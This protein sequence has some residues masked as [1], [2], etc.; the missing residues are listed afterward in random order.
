MD[1]TSGDMGGLLGFLAARSPCQNGSKEREMGRDGRG[2]DG[3]PWR[4]LEAGCKR[5]PGSLETWLFHDALAPRPLPVASPHASMRQGRGPGSGYHGKKGRQRR[6]WVKITMITDGNIGGAAASGLVV[7]Q[8]N[9]EQP[10]R[11]RQVVWASR[12]Q[13]V[14]K[15]IGPCR[16]ASR[17]G[18]GWRE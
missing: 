12:G 2:L 14:S 18:L 5:F 4:P 3:G 6:S 13:E 16:L 8:R 1:Y 11:R 9:E 15:M 7:P 10:P 17:Q